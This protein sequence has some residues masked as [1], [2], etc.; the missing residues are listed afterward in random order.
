MDFIKSLI[1]KADLDCVYKIQSEKMIELKIIPLYEK[2]SEIFV[3]TCNE[4]NEKK[5]FVEFLFGKKA[6]FINVDEIKF[7]K[8]F[9]SIR[10]DIY[11]DIEKEIILKVINKNGSDIHFE[12]S[13]NS[14]IIRARIDGMLTII[15][16]LRKEDYNQILSRIKLNANMDITEKRKPQDGK[17]LIT[18]DLDTFDCRISTVPVIYGE[19]MVIRILYQE[20]L[21]YSIEGLKLLDYQL[22]N[23]KKIINIK[24]GMVIIN[25]P[26]GSGKS[27]TLYSIISS[28]KE[29]D[30][31][32]T[33]IEDPVECNIQGINQ[34]NV[35]RKIN[36]GF[37]EGLRSILRQ[38]PDVIMVGEIRDEE[39]ASMAIRAAITGHKVYSTIHTKSSRE[40]FLRLEDMN[41]KNYLI[42]DSLVGA[43]SQ[44]LIGCLCNN[45]KIKYEGIFEGKVYNFY[46]ENGCEECNFTGIKGRRL[47]CAVHFI[48]E[49]K[50]RKFKDIYSDIELFSNKQM[51][52]VCKKLLLEGIISHNQYKK[53][54]NGED[55]TRYEE[56][57]EVFL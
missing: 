22:E 16:K 54:I 38:D 35:N 17:F 57:K 42:K 53:F 23:L 27:S 47:V 48:G 7:N 20:K 12:P 43:I 18:N 2:N 56:N 39:T 32:I 49:D 9:S 13:K 52:E 33:T 6:N 37:A 44:R 51:Y 26:T 1:E 3:V 15:G 36:F 30:I 29:K 40:V 19:K 50:K 31:N 14:V 28:I 24:N 8:L 10:F 45:C 41:I 5:D 4:N 46:K 25:G 34:M 11:K 21:D 55:L